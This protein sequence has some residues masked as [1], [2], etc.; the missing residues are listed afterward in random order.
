MA[1]FTNYHELPTSQ[2]NCCMTVPH[3]PAFC[4]CHGGSFFTS[5]VFKIQPSVPSFSAHTWEIGNAQGK[6]SINAGCSWIFHMITGRKIFIRVTWVTW[7]KVG[8][9]SNRQRLRLF[10]PR[11]FFQHCDLVS[12]LGPQK[13]FIADFDIFL[14]LA[15]GSNFFCEFMGGFPQSFIN[16]INHPQ[17]FCHIFGSSSPTGR[18]HL[19]GF[20]DVLPWQPSAAASAEWRQLPFGILRACQACRKSRENRIIWNFWGIYIPSG[21]LT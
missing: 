4:N 2:R 9:A 7:E 11:V 1:I 8:L 14:Q 15:H 17:W 10:I 12:H 19:I 21:K 18:F 20:H 6:S 16:F 5:W 13:S 3:P